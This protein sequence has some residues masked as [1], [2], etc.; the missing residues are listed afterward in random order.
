MIFVTLQRD[1]FHHRY[2]SSE[3]AQN[4]WPDEEDLPEDP[5]IWQPAAIKPAGR[6]HL[7]LMIAGCLLFAAV[8]IGGLVLAESQS[9][10][11]IT[12]A[13]HKAPEKPAEPAP[14]AAQ[15]TPSSVAPDGSI[16]ILP[17]DNPTI[18]KLQK[19]AAKGDVKAQYTLAGHYQ[20][21]RLVAADPK[22]AQALLG[23]AAASGHVPAMFALAR[24]YQDG[25]YGEPDLPRAA[26]WYEAAAATGHGPAALALGEIYE[27]GMDGPPDQAQ[28]L[29]WYQRAASYGSE[30]ALAGIARLSPKSTPVT[31]AEMR[32]LQE[33][34]NAKGLNAG[35]A[36]GKMST[37]TS[38]A[39]RAYQAQIGVMEDGRP[40]RFLLN[41]LLADSSQG[42]Q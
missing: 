2:A 1:L 15:V 28:A 9:K 4:L 42:D 16:S 6:S 10:P 12:L 34:L 29:G 41:H 37:R 14:V 20:D 31:A 17:S 13:T 23:N 21:G 8:G 27:K 35:P 19:A 36:T 24:A 11:E 18:L 38:E 30:Q 32:D 3:G 7:R 40:S 25:T 39:I 33:V 26:R 22:L 5:D